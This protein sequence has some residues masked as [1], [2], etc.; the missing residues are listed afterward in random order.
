MANLNKVLLIGNLTRD[1]ELRYLQSGTA[2]CDFG[3]A[4]NRRFKSAGGEQKEEVLF[5]DVTAFGKQAETVS[6]Y[7]QKGRPVFIEGRLKLDQWTGQDGQKRSRM[8]VVM[9]QFQFMD[10]RPGGAGGA[11]GANAGGG[12]RRAAP[13][14]RPQPAGS[15]PAG[16]PPAPKPSPA[17]PP[18]D[19]PPAANDFDSTEESIPF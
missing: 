11:G 1:P 9:E 15:P 2:V 13:P 14:N 18:Q 10:A 17:K 19:Q 3:I 7:L 4:V 12:E 6:E 8:S 5:V 16:S